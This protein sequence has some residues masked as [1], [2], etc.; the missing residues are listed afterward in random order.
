MRI[1]KRS[2]GG[3]G[4]YEIS[5]DAWGI[6]P[7]DLLNH[8]LVLALGAGIEIATG[9]QLLLRHGKRRLRIDELAGG[10]MQ[11]HRQLA[12]ALM[13]PYPARDE[14]TWAAGAPVMQS[15]LYGIGSIEFSS[16]MLLDKGI[17]CAAVAAIAA[18][19]RGGE[20]YVQ[21][22]ERIAAIQRVWEK[23]SDFPPPLARLIGE[24]ER[25]VRA[26]GP[27]GPHAETVVSSLQEAAAAYGHVPGVGPFSRSHDVLPV[28]LC[29]LQAG[30]LGEPP[31]TAGAGQEETSRP[32]EADSTSGGLP[33]G[34][35]AA[36]LPDSHTAGPEEAASAPDLEAAPAGMP[37]QDETAVEPEA[38]AS[39][40]Q[41]VL[42]ARTP[43]RPRPYRPQPR[44]PVVTAAGRSRSLPS[45]EPRDMSVPIEVRLRSR[46][47]GAYDLSFLPRRRAGMPAELGA[48]HAGQ[49]IQLRALHDDWYDDVVLP[50]AGRH[51]R[52]GMAWHGDGPERRFRWA[53]AGR[54]LYVLG[55]RDGLSGFVSVPRLVLGAQHIV[56]CTRHILQRVVEVLQGCC[57]TMPAAFDEQDGL[58]AGWVGLRPVVPALA[59]PPSA[60]GDILDALR[61]APEISIALEGGIR[62]QYSQFLAGYPP[63]VRVYGSLPAY[64]QV[65]IDGKP[66]EKA[67]ETFTAAGWDA[68]G[69]HVVACGAVSRTYMIVTPEDGWES[70]PAYSFSLP[71]GR[72]LAAAPSICGALVGEGERPQPPVVLVP[73]STPVLLGA[74][75]GQLYAA[76]VRQDIRMAVCPAFPGFSPVWA[77]PQEPLLAD[78]G[79]GRIL[80][81]DPSVPAAPDRH[82][83]PWRPSSA[84]LQWCKVI[85][86]CGR[87]GLIVEPPDEAARQLWRSYRALA[88][89]LWKASQ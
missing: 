15:G 74:Q 4:E 52:E 65:L 10:E 45:M 62:L 19:N 42:P 88:R 55:A 49:P 13:L 46:P 33:G 18:V 85:L 38:S 26:G 75:P 2:S 82:A 51:L 43:P 63:K 86:D 81:L 32:V 20:D 54:E 24:H 57:A 80:L 22:P 39:V 83:R 61:P 79:T 78:K 71:T 70:W 68:P 29:L 6:T 34:A 9:V 23:Q 66:A 69:E 37:E 31:G 72:R 21:G 84:A 16:V 64:A 77:V 58:P 67:D 60:A 56:L 14:R 11:L 87:K 7:R 30:A 76:P 28:L 3:R 27:L 47:G 44:S 25:L 12:A 35:E 48:S 17:A 41:A 50:E 5:Q 8:T 59:L 53:L 40:E 36:S 73:A 89:S 1:T